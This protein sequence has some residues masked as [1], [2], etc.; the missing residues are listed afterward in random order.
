MIADKCP[1]VFS[2]ALRNA[3]G[4]AVQF[5]R[6]Q[7]GITP[8]RLGLAL[9]ATR[10]RQHVE[11]SADVPG[12][13]QALFG[14]AIPSKAFSHQGAQP[15]CAD[16]ARTMAARLIREMTRTVLGFAPGHAVAACRHIVMQDG[17]SFAMHDGLR[18]GFP[19]R[20]P[21]LTPA[22]VALQTTMALRRPPW[23]GLPDTTS[24]QAFLPEPTALH[25]SVLL[26]DRGDVDGHSLRRVQ[27]A[28]GVFLIRA[29]AGMHPHVVEAF[30]DDGQRFRSLRTQS[31]Q[32]LHAQ[33]PK[34]QRGALL[35]Q[36]HVE[37]AS[38]GLRLLLSGNRRTKSCCSGL[39]HLPSKGDLIKSR[40]RRGG[41]VD[42]DCR[43]RAQPV[44]SLYAPPPRGGAQV[45]TQGGEV[46]QA[47]LR[48]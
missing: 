11:T 45:H 20:F 5:C 16:G 18:E 37:G 27:D 10:A 1:W 3:C 46:G 35:V 21:V 36:W 19:G 39:T 22:A 47:R 26:A 25:A 44:L 31:L 38:L 41:A 8:F 30:R 29:K 24:A 12:G 32:P 17:R 34:R 14:T 23:S 42:G 33:L 13:V 4:K 7:R 28:G 2:E 9:T 43:R 15:P 40:D 6:R 48:R